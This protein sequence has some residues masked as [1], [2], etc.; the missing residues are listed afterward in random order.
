[1]QRPFGPEGY[2]GSIFIRNERA[3]MVYPMLRYTLFDVGFA[4]SVCRLQNRF[5]ASS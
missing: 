3:I 4:K 1:M 2:F 5:P